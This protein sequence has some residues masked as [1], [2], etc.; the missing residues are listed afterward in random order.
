MKTRL[1]VYGTLKSGGSHHHHLAGQT[2]LGPAHTVPGYTLYLFH[3]GHDYPGMVRSP[4]AIGVSGEVWEVEK[5]C[6]ARLDVYEG[7]PEGLYERVPVALDP[8]TPAPTADAY[9]YLF[10]VTGRPHLGSD[11]PV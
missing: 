5:D 7:V 9:L 6:L 3:I 11:W 2:L 8:P 10:P 4:E 1:F